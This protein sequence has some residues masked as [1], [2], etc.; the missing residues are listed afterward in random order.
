MINFFQFKEELKKR[1]FE[2]LEK[3]DPIKHPTDWAWLTYASSHD[4]IK[5]NPIFKCALEALEKWALSQDAGKQE[6]HLAPLSIYVNFAK[7]NKNFEEIRKKAIFIF[8]KSIEK[9]ITK[10]SP[11]NDPEQVFSLSLISKHIPEENRK[12]LKRVIQKRINGRLLRSILYKASLIEIGNNEI[13]WPVLKGNEPPEDLITLIW[14]YER[15]REKHEEELSAIWKSFENI[16]PMINANKVDEDE[17]FINISNRSISFL[18]EAISKETHG[19]DPNMLFD[20]YPIHTRIR[21]ISEKHFKEGKYVTAVDQAT[22]VFNE[23]IQNKTG[24]TNKN[25]TDLVQSTMEKIQ[26][27]TKLKIKFN[28]FL[29]E[30]SGKNEQAGLALIARGIFK[31]FRNPKGH[32]PEDHPLVQ[33]NP[34]EAIDQL[35]IISYMMNR[36]EKAD[37]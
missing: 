36:I 30:V 5:N 6:R 19:Y 11:L 18:Y 13:D 14:F 29:N 33:L 22:K 37:S 9:E 8:V 23:F 34:Y 7:T 4:G 15:Y 10:F 24:I 12:G 21:E 31:A 27:P 1:I 26:N 2:R 32:K 25:E 35:I 17:G 28:R 3:T 20:V 16:K